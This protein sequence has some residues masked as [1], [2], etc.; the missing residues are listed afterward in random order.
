MK[1]NSL[2]KHRGKILMLAYFIG[3]L[4][5]IF[6]VSLTKVLIFCIVL[7]LI[8]QIFIKQKKLKSKRTKK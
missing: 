4:A 3:L 2:E 8:D 6:G 5:S 7:G 1:R